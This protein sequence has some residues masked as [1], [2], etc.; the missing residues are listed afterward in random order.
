[1]STTNYNFG[2]EGTKV[3]FKTSITTSAGNHSEDQLFV[4]FSAAC[5]MMN[6]DGGVIFI[7]VNDNGEI[8]KG[9]HYGVRGDKE[10]LGIR[11]NDGLARW[12]N[13]KITTYFY[14]DKYARGKMHAEEHSEDVI[15]IEVKK[16]EKVVFMHKKY[17]YDRLAFRRE[18]ASTRL[19][20]MKMIAQRENELSNEKAMLSTVSKQEHIR[21]RIFE[22]IERKKKVK[23]FGYCSSNSDSKEDR[24]LE[25]IKLICDGRSLWAYEEAKEGAEPCRQFRLC[26]IDNIK[27][28]DEAWTHESDHKEP[29]IDAFEWSR[30]TEPSIHIS[31]LVGP[32]A[33]NYLTE[34]SVEAKKYLTAVSADQWIFDTNVHSLAP[35]NRFCH[36]YTNAISL[37]S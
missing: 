31:I 2:F 23:L 22:A 17:S 26:R 24:I 32:S 7:G 30:T 37:C 5:A 34:N 9:P 20:D 29:H 21:L 15:C 33:K 12:I 16:A 25:P 13:Q 28:L 19:M 1:M 11:T 4:V 27:L 10:K 6:T 18:G 36:D 14:D 8:V 3:E 35:Y